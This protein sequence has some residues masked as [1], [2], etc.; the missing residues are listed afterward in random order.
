M[1]PRDRKAD[2]VAPGPAARRALVADDSAAEAPRPLRVL[3]AEDNAVNQRVAIRMLEKA[4]HRVVVA[5]DGRRALEAWRRE[6][7]DVVLMDVQMPEMDGLEALAAMRGQERTSGSAP[8]PVVAL[9][10]YAMKGDRERL[11]GS[12]FDGYLAK[13]IRS[14]DLL[15][16]LEDLM[17]RPVPPGGGSVSTQAPGGAVDLAAALARL[18]GDEDIL[19]ELAGLFLAESPRLRAAVGAAVTASDADA[20]KRSAHALKGMIIHFCAPAAHAVAERLETLGREG[21][22]D[23][24]EAA[25]AALEETL[26]PLEAALRDLVAGGRREGGAAGPGAGRQDRDVKAAPAGG[27]VLV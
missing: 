8:T 4:G 13:P 21:R 27:G 14:H 2:A 23:G 3:L 25:H 20:L 26:G 15:Q 22:L 10:S 19:R 17:P 9:T 5:E 7:F 11:L 16:T 1:S 6:P 24:A 18:E 12:G